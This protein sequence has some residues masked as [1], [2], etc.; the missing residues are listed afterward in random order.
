M[1]FIPHPPLIRIPPFLVLALLAVFACGRKEP[2]VEKPVPAGEALTVALKG[3]HCQLRVEAFDRDPVTGV[4]RMARVTFIDLVGEPGWSSEFPG[5]KAAYLSEDAS[6]SVVQK[7]EPGEGR[8][9]LMVL[10]NA[11]RQ[12]LQTITLDERVQGEIVLSR[13]GR[14]AA[15]LGQQGTLFHISVLSGEV[16]RHSLGPEAGGGLVMTCSDDGVLT[17]V[18]GGGRYTKSFRI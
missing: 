17:C 6:I 13:T 15:A 12:L 3:N 8:T 14:Y 2:P 5:F 4:S 10:F 18:Y 16:R 1:K 9:P 7:E 11:R